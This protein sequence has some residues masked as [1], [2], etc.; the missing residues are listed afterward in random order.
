MLSMYEMLNDLMV[1]MLPA[2]FS[3]PSTRC[4]KTA[5]GCARCHASTSSRW[6]GVD[7]NGT[8]TEADLDGVLISQRLG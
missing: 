7:G 3:L 6:H 2:S 1:S 4:D 8:S 5:I